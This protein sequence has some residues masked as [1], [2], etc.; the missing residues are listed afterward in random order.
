MPK[1]RVLDFSLN[2]VYGTLLINC[3]MQAQCSFSRVPFPL[4]KV[5]KRPKTSLNWRSVSVKR[6]GAW[7]GGKFSKSILKHLFPVA[8]ISSP[9]NL[10]CVC[11]FIFLIQWFERKTNLTYDTFYIYCKHQWRHKNGKNSQISIN[12]QILP[13]LTCGWGGASKTTHTHS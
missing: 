12:I 3:A 8:V 13:Q 7:E 1:Y 6:G 9:A 5:Q 2:N 11:C 10:L 4:D